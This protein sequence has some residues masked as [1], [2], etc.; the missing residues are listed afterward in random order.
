[1]HGCSM[2]GR[3]VNAAPGTAIADSSATLFFEWAVDILQPNGM[4]IGTIMAIGWGGAVRPPGA[5]SQILQSNMAVVGGT[6]AYLG[7]QGQAGQGGNTIAPR[8]GSMREDPA[9]RRI[10]GGGARRYV[11]HLFPMARPE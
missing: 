3:A 6:G 10:N 7:V 11:F 5:P 4:P 2:L 8:F 9:N 1:M